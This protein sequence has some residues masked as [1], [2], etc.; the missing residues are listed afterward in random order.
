MTEALQRSCYQL[1]Q[2]QTGCTLH[3]H[4]CRSSRRLSSCL[5]STNQDKKEQGKAGWLA[6]LPTANR[7]MLVQVL[8]MLMV[9]VL[10]VMHVRLL[11]VLLL[12]VLLLLLP[13]PSLERRYFR[14]QQ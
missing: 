7:L 5:H 8:L 2:M 13:T 14:T 10:H 4:T 11:P 9:L 3:D 6:A 1:H 12:H